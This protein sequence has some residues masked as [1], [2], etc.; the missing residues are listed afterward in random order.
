[1]SLCI[2]NQKKDNCL[3]SDVLKKIEIKII[4][5]EPKL[6]TH[7]VINNEVNTSNEDDKQKIIK[8]AQHT[9]CTE[10]TIQEKEV[11]ILE[12]VDDDMSRRLLLDYFKPEA[13]RVDKD[14]WIT[15]TEID[16]VQYQFQ[17]LHEGYY[18]SNIHMI[19]L[20][21]FDP[22]T[23]H[24]ME[25]NVYPIKEINFVEE[26]KGKRQKLTHNGKL[27]TYGLV[28]NTD[29]S[30][31]RGKHWFSIF[32]DFQS[33]PITIE[34]FNSSGMILRND[35]FNTYF[36]TLAATITK[37]LDMPCKYKKVTDIQH[38]SD[39]TSNCGAYS[40]YYIWKRLNGTAHDFFK[41]NKIMDEQVEEFRKFCFRVKNKDDK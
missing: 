28:V 31:G 41:K 3:P 36:H 27:K 7:E 14:Y 12:K 8:L 4:N 33:R 10:G 22:D 1:M 25:H 29:K 40:L 2:L 11:C 38:Q 37:Q 13:P 16:N 19:D 9:N 35:T 30:S 24:I 5:K 20:V 17:K 6:G 21:M 32:I 34:Y 23:K 18:Y 15:N 26:L 39:E